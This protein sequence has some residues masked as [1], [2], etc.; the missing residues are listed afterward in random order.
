MQLGFT[1]DSF[2]G[3]QV[4]GQAQRVAQSSERG[5][6]GIPRMLPACPG[7]QFQVSFH[8]ASVG[9]RCLPGCALDAPVPLE[10]SEQTRGGG[11]RAR[12][13]AHA[14]VLVFGKSR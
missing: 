14:L 1:S 7:L 3:C 10:I 9:S 13:L 8:G 6:A 11:G 2:G 5:A 12:V 4:L